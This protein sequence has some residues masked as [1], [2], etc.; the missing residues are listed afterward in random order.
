MSEFDHALH[1]KVDQLD[2][3]VTQ[4]GQLVIEVG[5]QIDGVRQK[6]QETDD[7]LQR[8]ADDFAAFVQQAQRTANAQRAETRTGVLEAQLEH[9]FGHHKV[10]RRCAVGLLQGFDVGLLS[11]ETVRAVGEQLMV[12]N[13]RYWLAPVLVALGAW[14]GDEPELCERA[15]AEAFR[16]SPGRTSLFMALVLRRQ[17]RRDGSVRWLRHFLAVQD[18]TALGRDFAV[19]LECIAQG[20][21][22]PAG[23]DL[24]RE[25]LAAW[26]ELLLDDEGKHQAQVDRWRAEVERH[27]AGSARQRFPRLAEVSPQWPALDRALAR[28]SAHQPL[29]DRY[30]ALA[31][32]A[33]TAQDRLEDAVDDILDRLVNEYDEEELPLRRE[34]ALTAAVIRHGGDEEAARREVAQDAAALEN[35]LDY[36]TIQTQ[37]ALTP[38]AIGVSRSTQRIAIGACHEW[39][40]RAHAEFTRDYRAALPQHVEAVFES[41]HNLGATVFE[42]PR[43]TG[44]LSRPLDELEQSLED[45]WDATAEPYLDSFTFDWPKKALLPAVVVVVALVVFAAC[46]GWVGALLALAGGGVWA[47]VLNNQA[48]TAANRRQ[49]AFDFIERAKDDSIRQLRG[50][51]AERTDWMAA[52]TAAD[53]R[54]PAVRALIADLALAASGPHRYEQRVVESAAGTATVGAGIGATDQSSQSGQ[55]NQNNQTATAVQ[56]SPTTA[57]GA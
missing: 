32:E 48:Q 16:R 5:G 46:G 43:W 29:L 35:T 21:F 15:V 30:A 17:D 57:E 8:L 1:R 3:M 50:A 42:L 2:N 38:E 18:P 34:L 26:R 31:A 37:S 11:E 10:V 23:L 55:A 54:E 12:Q 56:V 28:A 33:P 40:S 53:S 6:T 51:A 20:A 49:E 39:F 36:L 14:A 41:S 27:V 19:I 4:V 13:P 25:R 44:S 24:V 52:F 7:R 47:M 22:G 45:H 9:Q